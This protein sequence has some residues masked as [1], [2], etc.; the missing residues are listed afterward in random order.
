LPTSPLKLWIYQNP[1]RQ[2]G[3]FRNTAETQNRNPSLTHRVGIVTNPKLHSPDPIGK[4]GGSGHFQGL[5]SMKLQRNLQFL[6]CQLPVPRECP[7]SNPKNREANEVAAAIHLAPQ[8]VF[9]HHSSCFDNPRRVKSPGRLSKP[10]VSGK[11]IDLT[12]F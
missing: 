12:S 8:E 6:M 9:C 7:C 5:G 11:S 4:T 1:K 10:S 3:I 2:R